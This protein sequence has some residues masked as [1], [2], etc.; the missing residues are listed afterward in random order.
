MGFMA[1]GLLI[2]NRK[3]LRFGGFFHVHSVINMAVPSQRK[4]I[5]HSPSR[6]VG[7]YHLMG[8]SIRAVPFQSDPARWQRRTL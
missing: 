3:V 7:L 8:A 6:S 1:G 2:S 5:L 4:K